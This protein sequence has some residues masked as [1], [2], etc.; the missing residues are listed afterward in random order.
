NE[1]HLPQM[2]TGAPG[3]RPD[4]SSTDYALGWMVDTYRGHQRV[5]HGGNIDGFSANVVLFPKDGVGI[6]VLTNLNGTPLRDLIT[7]VIADRL[8]K[9]EKVEW[10]AAAAANRARS[11]AAAKEGEKKK[12]AARIAGTQPAH[13]LV[14]YTGEYEH[15]GY[16][17]LK[18][19][20]RD[21]KL[22]A[23][24]NNITTPLE[25]WHYETFNGG[26]GEEPTFENMKYTFQTDVKGY[27]AKLA[28]AFEPSVNEIVFV[29][30]PDARLFDAAYLARFT[31]EYDLLGQTI[32]VSLKGN[33]L[34][35]Q[36]AN[37]PRSELVP[38]VDGDFTP[39][40]SRTVSWHFVIDE[41][42]KVAAVELRQPSTVLMAKKKQ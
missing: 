26:K 42:G 7:R 27:V 18:V 33:T 13:K 21:G 35:T 15:P 12:E 17:V 4:I 3:E 40:L 32:T 19:A 36:T 10:L 38:G 16:G 25:H 41:S 11:E 23:T 9:L 8:F 6:V 31:G 22:E 14:D 5:Q 34:T 24:Y 2:A 1:M 37:Q 39:K 29:K 20:L 28:A 30:K